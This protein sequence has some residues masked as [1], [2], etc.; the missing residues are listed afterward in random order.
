MRYWNLV[1]KELLGSCYIGD[2]WIAAKTVG[3][4]GLARRFDHLG[5]RKGLGSHLLDKRTTP[6]CLCKVRPREL[7]AGKGA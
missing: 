6:E 2:D 5:L 4:Q 3:N 7:V 1:L